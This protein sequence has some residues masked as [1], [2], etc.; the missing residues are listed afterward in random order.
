MRQD[1][2][3][4]H[5]ARLPDGAFEALKDRLIEELS[6][7]PPKELL[8]ALDDRRSERVYAWIGKRIVAL[9]LY[10]AGTVGLGA[11]A[12]IQYLKAKGVI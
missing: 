3:R 9:V 2:E 5:H 6:E 1:I 4:R 11:L 8:D 7:N 10:I 12:I